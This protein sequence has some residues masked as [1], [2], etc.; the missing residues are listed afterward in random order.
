MTDLAAEK[1]YVVS[2]T[3]SLNEAALPLEDSR[4]L[5]SPIGHTSSSPLPAWSAPSSPPVIGDIEDDEYMDLEASI[6]SVE[7]LHIR[8]AS[9]LQVQKVY[10]TRSRTSTLP[11]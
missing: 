6:A 8:R 1:H 5:H 10:K 9:A 7:R 3:S 4:S 11:G 2:R